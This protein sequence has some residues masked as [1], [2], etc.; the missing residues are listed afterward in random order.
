MK[1][2][3]STAD[4]PSPKRTGGRPKS[5]DPKPARATV[6]FT[7]I[8]YMVVK[9]RV[10]NVRLTVADYCRQAVLTAKVSPTMDP[11]ML[12]ALHELRELSNT[13]NQLAKLA[14]ADG[15]PSVGFKANRLL[16]ELTKLLA[17]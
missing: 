15:L 3:S 13:L 9:Q 16:D 5:L 6:R 10:E 11:A 17:V 7:K 2:A 12:P 4:T 1:A 14:Q 8:E